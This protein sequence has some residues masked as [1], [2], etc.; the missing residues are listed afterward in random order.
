MLFEKIM[1]IF[2][3][4]K[5]YREK[6]ANISVFDH[7]FLYGDGIFET[8]RAYN[9][10]VFEIDEHIK[11][12]LNSAA[13]IGLKIPQNK[14]KLKEAVYSAI[15][16]NKL[17]NAYIRITVSRG[18]GSLGY[19]AKCVPNIIIIAKQFI[20]YPKRMYE[21][22]VQAATFN[23]E[24]V[25]P[26]VKST[27][28]LPLVVAKINTGKYFEAFLVD[29]KGNITEGTVSNIFFV[30]SNSLYTPREKI[31]FGVTR[32]IVKKIAQG[33]GLQLKEIKIKKSEIYSFEECF[34]ASTLVE[35]MP[36]V[37]INGKK[38][39]NGLPGP[40]TK[41]LI[42]EFKKERDTWLRQSTA[43]NMH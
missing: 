3:N 1:H 17:M 8:L 43:E 33:I 9:G 10:I 39:N 35:I 6:D 21:K 7:G 2:I 13:L 20:P 24:R 31:L 18:K 15:R 36:V 30:K 23:A 34:L 5:F 28:C 41:K 25:L 26:Q 4:N 14:A 11:R 40:I 37:E 22:G 12:L 29:N 32:K 16:K 38:I 42:E 19:A 27:S